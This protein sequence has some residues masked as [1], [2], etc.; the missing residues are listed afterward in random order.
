ML[1]WPTPCTTRGSCE[2]DR[3]GLLCRNHRDVALS[4]RSP[5]H[6]VEADLVFI[7]TDLGV[8]ALAG[9]LEREQVTALVHDEEFA[10]LLDWVPFTGFRLSWLRIGRPGST[11][12]LL[13]GSGARRRR[14]RAAVVVCDQDIGHHGD[15]EG[16]RAT[17]PGCGWVC[18]VTS[19]LASLRLR[20]GEA[21][22][23][24]PPIFTASDWASSPLR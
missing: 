21:M 15:A 17:L 20:S 14:F 22:L 13:S 12:D 2:G 7:S 18:S 9:V 19:L 1:R 5:G 8:P 3:L 16:A 23:I 10:P 24:Q 4:L 6:A 11:L